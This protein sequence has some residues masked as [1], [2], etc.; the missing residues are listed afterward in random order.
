MVHLISCDKL[1]LGT[2]FLSHTKECS[3]SWWMV[4]PSPEPQ[5]S[6]GREVNDLNVT[7]EVCGSSG[8]KYNVQ[9]PTALRRQRFQVEKR[10]K[11][12]SLFGKVNQVSCHQNRL[13]PK[14]CTYLQTFS[15]SQ[16]KY[17]DTLSLH[18]TT[19]LILGEIS[20]MFFCRTTYV[21]MRF[22]WF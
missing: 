15:L 3:G 9:I 21:T 11:E 2:C 4:R 13:S 16:L 20:T 5:S 19:W 8:T 17:S 22:F 10:E 18:R 6:G 14:G 12:I 1:F 7:R